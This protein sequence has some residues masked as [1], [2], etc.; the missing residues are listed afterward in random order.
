MKRKLYEML[1]LFPLFAFG[2]SVLL[3]I[4][5]L[6]LRNVPTNL[7]YTYENGEILYHSW[8][9]SCRPLFLPGFIVLAV[10][11]LA[12]AVAYIVAGIKHWESRS[13][14]G[15]AA[16]GALVTVV[17]CAFLWILSYMGVVGNTIDEYEPDYYEFS[18]QAHTI[19]I[20]ESSWLLGGFGKVF[21]IKDNQEAVLILKF[22]TDDGFRNG[23]NYQLEWYDDHVDMTFNCGDRS[24]PHMITKSAYFE[25]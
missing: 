23:G 24:S 5:M 18:N 7:S 25:D 4:A 15:I 22:L 6:L 2:A 3:F 21:Q 11:L 12:S 20:E 16:I 13:R 14:A 8:R 19:V 1:K 17:P 9:Y 10:L